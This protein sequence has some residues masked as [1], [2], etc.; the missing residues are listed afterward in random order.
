MD[1]NFDDFTICKWNHDS[2]A[3]FQWTINNGSTLSLL[4]G[5]TADHTT[6]SPN[7]HYIFIEASSPQKQN[8]AARLLSKYVNIG[9]NGGCFK[10]FY[11]MY[12]AD[13]YRLNVYI[14]Q[15]SSA[16]GK[17]VWQK[18]GNKGNDWLFGHFYVDK[19]TSNT[20]FI[21]EGIVK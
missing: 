10:F 5:P 18:E 6:E 13:I 19:Q 16:Y 15:G 8:D 1:C 14:Q 20:R 3:Q 2:T 9:S 12:G 11:H 21:L 17:P 7:G 4:T